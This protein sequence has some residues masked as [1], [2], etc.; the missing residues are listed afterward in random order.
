VKK[1]VKGES[2]KCNV[3][4]PNVDRYLSSS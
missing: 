2:A 1:G 4:T 3:L